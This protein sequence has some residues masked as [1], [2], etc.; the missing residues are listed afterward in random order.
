MGNN[1]DVAF[2]C[3]LG[4]IFSDPSVDPSSTSTISLSNTIG[5][6]KVGRMSGIHDQ[7]H[8]AHPVQDLMQCR[9]FVVDRDQNRNFQASSL[10]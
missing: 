10:F 6:F 8:R 2:G 7:V 4:R 9:L 3:F 1:F 5:A